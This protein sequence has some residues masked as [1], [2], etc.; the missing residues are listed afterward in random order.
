MLTIDLLRRNVLLVLHYSHLSS[1]IKKYMS[2]E[3]EQIPAL[4]RM[5]YQLPTANLIFNYTE[6]DWEACGVDKT[7]T[8]ESHF[9]RVIAPLL[10]AANKKPDKKRSRSLVPTF[11]ELSV[12]VPEG[13]LP[14]P[15]STPPGEPHSS[16]TVAAAAPV[17]DHD[18]DEDDDLVLQLQAQL[19]EQQGLIQQQEQRIVDLQDALAR[20]KRIVKNLQK[21]RQRHRAASQ[22]N[23]QQE[24]QDTEQDDGNGAHVQ[25]AVE[26]GDG[27]SGQE[28]VDGLEQDDFLEDTAVE[29]Q[30]EREQRTE[31]EVGALLIE[32]MNRAGNVAHGLSLYLCIYSMCVHAEYTHNLYS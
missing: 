32:A 20:E 25:E 30:K 5:Q 31:E 11:Q 28:D 1:S 26:S 9:I 8:V 3:I 7:S 14:D 13:G 23:Q 12:E 4:F 22:A 29:K 10:S 19:H 27:D 16:A 21:Q 18:D 2:I 17:R 6:I 15:V 24:A